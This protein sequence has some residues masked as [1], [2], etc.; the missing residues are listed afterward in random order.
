MKKHNRGHVGMTRY[1]AIKDATVNPETGE[2]DD[3]GMVVKTMA[4]Y[5]TEEMIALLEAKMPDYKGRIREISKEEYERDY[6]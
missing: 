5:P 3:A 2:R 4:A 6:E 1:F